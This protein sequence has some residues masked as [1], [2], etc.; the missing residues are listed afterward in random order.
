M[1]HL[2]HAIAFI[3]HSCMFYVN[4]VLRT[5]TTVSLSGLSQVAMLAVKITGGCLALCF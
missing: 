1:S 4:L 5:L 3:C 2:I